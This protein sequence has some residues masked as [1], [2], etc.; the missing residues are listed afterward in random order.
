MCYPNLVL[1]ILKELQGHKVSKASNDF[2]VPLCHQFKNNPVQKEFFLQRKNV[3]I[4]E[5]LQFSNF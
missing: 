1:K 4:L 3:H 5:K 2:K